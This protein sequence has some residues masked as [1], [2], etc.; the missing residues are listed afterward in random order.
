MA[1]FLISV[2][3]HTRYFMKKTTRTIMAL[4]LTAA[5]AGCATV[6]ITPHGE[7][8]LASSP[9]YES[10]K[11]F[12]LFGLIGERH[13]DVQDICQSRSV[14]QMQTVDTFSDRLLTF[15]TLGIYTPRTARV[16]CDGEGNA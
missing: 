6:T 9:T 3:S 5:L 15:V 2:A 12:F 11:A 4:S 10:K 1:R 7:S 8:K 14:R 13:V 16:W